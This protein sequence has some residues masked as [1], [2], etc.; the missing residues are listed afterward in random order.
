MPVVLRFGALA[1]V[2]RSGADLLRYITRAEC[3]C[4]TA[5]LSKSS[6]CCWAH[7]TELQVEVRTEDGAT[8]TLEEVG[9]LS[10]KS[11]PLVEVAEC[12][13]YAAGA[14]SFQFAPS[15]A[16]KPRAD[17][18]LGGRSFVRAASLE[19]TGRLDPFIGDI[20]FS[21]CAPSANGELCGACVR[22][23]SACK[24]ALASDAQRKV[25]R[26]RREAADAEKAA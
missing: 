11:S 7:S 22:S 16:G 18:T 3:T 6:Q 17:V 14:L 20:G 25:S 24:A 4:E 12:V 1:V 10:G 23:R 2:V 9:L 5:A 8:R 15:R 13:L 21:C 19:G 26:S